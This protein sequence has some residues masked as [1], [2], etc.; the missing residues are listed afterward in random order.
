MARYHFNPYTGDPGKCSAKKRCP[1]GD[2]E[3]EHFATSEEATKA[4]EALYAPFHQPVDRREDKYD[5]PDRNESLHR[6]FSSLHTPGGTVHFAVGRCEWGR[7]SPD[8]SMEAWLSTP[9]GGNV[10]FIKLIYHNE[11]YEPSV[12]PYLAMCDVE[13][14]PNMRGKGMARELRE[15]IEAETGLLIYSSGS[16]TPEGWAAFGK[17][18][19]FIPREYASRS[20][21]PGEKFKSMGFVASWRHKIASEPD[22]SI[23]HTN[24]QRDAIWELSD[25]G[26]FDKLR[27][28]EVRWVED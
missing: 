3:T 20:D 9:E 7:E 16:Y 24:E 6:E 1:F 12:G 14:R 27:N 5:W 17:H 26:I 13:T 22:R 15:S 4:Y 23:S 19:R 8:R 21:L 10:S 25:T 28:K 11:K 18:G 2:S